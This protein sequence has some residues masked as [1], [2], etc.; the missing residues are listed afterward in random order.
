MTTD[1]GSEL[2]GA[3]DVEGL[4]LSV[5]S[6]NPPAGLWS[7]VAGADPDNIDKRPRQQTTIETGPV[8]GNILQV[9]TQPERADWH[10]QPSPPPGPPPTNQ[11]PMLS[12]VSESMDILRRSRDAAL[13]SIALVNRLAFGALLIK[14][15]SDQ[16]EGIQ[17]LTR[18]LSTVRLTD[19]SREFIY[20]VNRRTRLRTEPAVRV[21]RVA[22][23]SVEEIISVGIAMPQ[24]RVDRGAQ[25]V[26]R[27]LA[28]D[29]NTIPAGARTTNNTKPWFDELVELARE[30]AVKG[31]ID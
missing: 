3:W 14:Q 12:N 11:V 26:V 23:W 8:L 30:I 9:V 1:S 25:V 4:R 5:F 15:V 21:N 31:D 16:S 6:D 27:K 10:I 22:A 7:K 28:L 19:D 17:A 20:R 2:F 29:I 24:M 13:D 18:Y